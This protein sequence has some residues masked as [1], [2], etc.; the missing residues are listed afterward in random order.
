LG[1]GFTK[2]AVF[3][4]VF[5]LLDAHAQRAEILATFHSWFSTNDLQLKTDNSLS[6][7]RWWKGQSKKIEGATGV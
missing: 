6:A 2:G 3:D 1:F 7:R 5:A 4:F